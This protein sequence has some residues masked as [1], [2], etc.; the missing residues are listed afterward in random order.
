LLAHYK[1]WP[2][3]QPGGPKPREAARALIV[4]LG[5]A[6]DARLAAFVAVVGEHDPEHLAHLLLA[7]C[8]L[9]IEALKGAA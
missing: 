3:Y 4:A 6:S 7:P 5:E 8:H 2:G 1:D 9:E